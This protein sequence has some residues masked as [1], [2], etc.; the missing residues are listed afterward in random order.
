[1]V[2]PAKRSDTSVM[3]ELLAFVQNKLDVKDELS[4]EQICT[5]SFTEDEIHAAKVVMHEIAATGPVRFF[6]R[7]KDVR[8]EQDLR[9]ILRVLNKPLPP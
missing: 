3:C 7:K 6:T 8:G 4:L 2:N 5:S 1:M 9:D